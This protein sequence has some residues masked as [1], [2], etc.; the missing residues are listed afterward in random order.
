MYVSV[1]VYLCELENKRK[2][3]NWHLNMR[4]HIHHYVYEYVDFELFWLNAI[5]WNDFG[6]WNC[7]WE[8]QNQLGIIINYI[9]R[10]FVLFLYFERVQITKNE[11]VEEWI[12]FAVFVYLMDRDHFDTHLIKYSFDHHRYTQMD[13]RH[14]GHLQL[15][16]SIG[17]LCT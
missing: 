1:Y 3:M 4:A 7:K 16:H 15:C 6:K 10:I 2:L 5:R 11:N 12:E 8:N 14:T 9:R 17:L 13:M